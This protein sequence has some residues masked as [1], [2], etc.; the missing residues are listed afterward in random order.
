[1]RSFQRLPNEARIDAGGSM[2]TLYGFGRIFPE[3]RGETKD[4][5]AQ[6]ALE[7][8]GLPYRVHALDHTGGELDGEAYGRI[9]PFHQAPVIDDDGFVVAESAAIVLY[10]A[11]KAGKLI[12]SDVHGRIRV[13]QWCFAAVSTVMPTLT[14]IDLIEIF[15]DRR[16]PALKL[17]A[18]VHK[19]ARR[20]LADVER[21]LEAREWIACAEFTVADILLAGVLRA[22]RKTDLLQPYSNLKA[23]YD[24][25][26]ARPAWQR[27][28]GLY[29][30]RLG[31][32]VDD[33]R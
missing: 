15:D 3:G 13:V 17:K 26:L 18:E 28:L 33:I 22:A 29:A 8:T 1:V 23:Y 11:E 20:W 9:S 16:N 24:R 25:C 14:C 7:E 30:E 31:V 19:L 4:L 27:T 2:I 5:W 12:P 10:L 21:R 6:W 32:R